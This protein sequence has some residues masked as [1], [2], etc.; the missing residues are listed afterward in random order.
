[1]YETPLEGKSDT[2][3]DQY[4][5]KQACD[6]LLHA[7]MARLFIGERLEVCCHACGDLSDKLARKIL[8][9]GHAVDSYRR[10]GIA[11]Q[12]GRLVLQALEFS[13]H[14]KVLITL[15][16][17][18]TSRLSGKKSETGCVQLKVHDG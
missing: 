6:A 8:F 7:K 1:M 12:Y 3:V 11:T 5:V 14:V 15:S 9:A 2:H 4:H 13:C 17:G 18:K 10:E 16:D